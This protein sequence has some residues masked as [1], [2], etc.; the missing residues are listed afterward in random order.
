MSELEIPRSSDSEYYEHTKLVQ[1]QTIS[2]RLH[3][4]KLESQHIKFW[5]VM[6]LCINTDQL[7][8]S[9]NIIQSISDLISQE[10]VER[11][12]QLRH[13][14]NYRYCDDPK[15]KLRLTKSIIMSSLYRLPSTVDISPEFLSAALSVHR[16]FKE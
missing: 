6:K 16:H 11:F 1:S 3:D 5:A 9:L 7:L 13:L 4:P 2:S 14:I 10:T 8:E 12:R 15:N